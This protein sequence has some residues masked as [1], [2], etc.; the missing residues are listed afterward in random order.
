MVE[1]FEDALAGFDVGK[2]ALTQRQ[3]LV[4]ALRAGGMTQAQIATLWGTSRS[5]VCMLEKAAKSKIEKARETIA[6]DE[7][8]RAPLR[9]VFQPGEL[10]LDIPP[11]LYRAADHAQIKVRADGPM[12]MQQVL[13]QAPECVLDNRLVKAILVM[14]TLEGHLYVK[15]LP[16]GQ[17]APVAATG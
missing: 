16:K 12:V 9:L 11:R 6:F 3:A 4:W 2:L 10:L 14:V 7:Q 17:N 8:L 1:D 5:N 13:S 15:A